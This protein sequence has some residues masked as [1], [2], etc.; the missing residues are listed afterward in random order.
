MRLWGRVLLGQPLNMYVYAQVRRYV[1]IKR[2]VDF[3]R[4]S[5]D[6]W[7]PFALTIRIRT[8]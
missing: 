5:I 7:T 8:A 4:I 6:L 1:H 2:P 3:G